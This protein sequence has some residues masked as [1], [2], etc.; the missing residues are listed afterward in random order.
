MFDGDPAP[1]PNGAE[2]PIFR[3][4]L[5]RPNGC[6]NQDATWYG[7]RPRPDDIVLDG[8]PAPPPQKGGR[9]PSPIFSLC[10]RWIKMAL[11]VEV[12]D[13]VRLKSGVPRISF[14]G[15]KFKV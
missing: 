2:P 6:M 7:D 3:P 11:G 9:A 12:G 14:W 13:L 5:L 8:D 4:C 1:S 10:L 15:Y